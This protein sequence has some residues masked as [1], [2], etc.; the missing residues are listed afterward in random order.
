MFKKIATLLFSALSLSVLFA[1]GSLGAESADF[2]IYGEGGNCDPESGTAVTV[3]TVANSADGGADA[4]AIVATYIGGGLLTAEYRAISLNG[5]SSEMISVE[6]QIPTDGGITQKIMLWEGLDTMK[7]LTDAKDL[8]LDDTPPPPTPPPNMTSR[9]FEPT[10]ELL[11]NPHIGFTTFQTFNGQGGV[12]SRVFNDYWPETIFSDFDPEAEDAF[13][14]PGHPDTSVAYVRLH[15]RSLEPEMGQYNWDLM[16]R[17]L[18]L[19]EQRHQTF[20]LR[21][22]FY[23]LG[24]TG[25]SYSNLPDYIMAIPG[26]TDMPPERNDIDGWYDWMWEVNHNNEEFTEHYTRF[27]KALAER[28]DG[29]RYLDSVDIAVCGNCSENLGILLMDDDKIDAVIHAYID[30]FKVTPLITFLS[31]EGRAKPE[32]ITK[33]VAIRVMEMGGKAGY[34]ADS[35]GDM[36]GYGLNWNYMMGAWPFPDKAIFGYPWMVNLFNE[37]SRALNGGKEAW[38]MGTVSFEAGWHMQDWYDEPSGIKPPFHFGQIPSVPLDIA[39]NGQHRWDLDLIIDR[40]YEW[41]TSTFHNKSNVIP[42]PWL[43]KVEEWQK[44]LGYRFSLSK[45]EYTEELTGRD[46]LTINSTWHN[47]GVAPIYHPWYVVAYRIKNAGG[48]YVFISETDIREWMPGEWIRGTF[49][50]N[51]YN[52]DF[53]TVPNP[54]YDPDRS[55]GKFTLTEPGE[56]LPS[57]DWNDANSFVLPADIINGTYDLQVAIV[58]A[59]EKNPDYPEYGGAVP[60]GTPVTLRIADDADMEPAIRLANEGREDDGWITVGEVTVR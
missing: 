53:N 20:M 18:R 11:I 30:Y 59:F 33:N 39:L 35:F 10:D 31:D 43:E 47:L 42:E 4:V 14:N 38:Q 23:T 1:V 21:I 50:W 40:S 48:E 22:M 29:H 13:S 54:N 2:R 49:K 58:N 6:T 12:Y 19:A 24:P 46:K 7:P 51:G 60:N 36:G 45:I 52:P 9:T 8:L 27:I 55:A 44:G 37:R 15:W 25:P 57:P 56:L 26:I 3:F 32:N 17:M 28:Y 34:R 5:H 41:N 16:D